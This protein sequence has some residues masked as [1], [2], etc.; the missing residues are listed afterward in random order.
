MISLPFTASGGMG[1][2][3]GIWLI[4]LVLMMVVEPP[5]GLRALFAHTDVPAQSTFAAPTSFTIDLKVDPVTVQLDGKTVTINNTSWFCT[6]QDSSDEQK[7]NWPAGSNDAMVATVQALKVLGKFPEH[8]MVMRVICKDGFKDRPKHPQSGSRWCQKVCGARISLR[9]DVFTPHTCL[10]F[11]AMNAS[12]SR[13]HF[14]HFKWF[15]SYKCCNQ[16]DEGHKRCV[17]MEPIIH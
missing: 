7:N 12:K 5:I 2:H 8:F 1:Y 11:Q 17:G 16:S 9:N 14:S 6:P 10:V 4:L 15:I 3:I 13:G